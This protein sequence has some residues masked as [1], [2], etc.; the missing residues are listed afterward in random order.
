[1]NNQYDMSLSGSG[2]HAPLTTPPTQR[3][4][5]LK[6]IRQYHEMGYELLE[7]VAC[8]ENFAVVWLR[9]KGDYVVMTYVYDGSSW[10]CQ[11]AHR[12]ESRPESAR[13]YWSKREALGV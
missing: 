12:C 2:V 11:E 7:P 4:V 8:D 3:Y 10:K 13:A 5:D 1:M 9:D 6:N